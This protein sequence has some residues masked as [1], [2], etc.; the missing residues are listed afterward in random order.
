M[1]ERAAADRAAHVAAEQA[2]LDIEL[3]ARQHAADC[4]RQAEEA[5]Q[6]RVVPQQ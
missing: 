5:R 2:K 6:V 1:R 3:R 4:L